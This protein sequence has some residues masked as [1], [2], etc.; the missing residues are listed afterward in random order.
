MRGLFRT[1]PAAGRAAGFAMVDVV[2]VAAAVHV[3]RQGTAKPPVP[4]TL[5]ADH[6]TPLATAMA[7]CQTLGM[8]AAT[9]TACQAAWA[10][11]RRRFFNNVSSVEGN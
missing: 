11:N 6:A 3:H 1:I 9:N 4:I 7:R 5:A 10:E 8:A 2:I